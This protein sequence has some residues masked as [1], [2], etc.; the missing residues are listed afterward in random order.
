[1][2]DFAAV[3]TPDFWRR[4]D[5]LLRR[6][7][8]LLLLVFAVF[9]YGQ[10]YRSDL[11]LGGEGGTAAVNALRLNEGWLP[12]KDTTLNYNVMWFYPVAW[13]F[14]LTGPDYVALRIYFFAL[15][16]V[17]GILGF[18]I[19]RRVTGLGWYA[20]GAGLLILAIPGMLFRNYMGL[21]P[22]LNA[23]ALLHAFVLGS[24]AG[25]RRWLWFAG[26]GFVL[27]LT[28]LVRIDVGMFFTV[29]Y[30]G[31]VALY[32]LGVRGEFGRRLPVAV[33]GGVL[34]ALAAV[35]IHL[36]FYLDACRRG[37]GPEFIG[38][39]TTIWNQTRYEVERRLPGKRLARAVP[40][41]PVTVAPAVET[42]WI[43]VHFK[44]TPKNWAEKAK[45]EKLAAMNRSGR[46]RQELR[47]LFRQA[48]FYDA[49]FV[50]ILHLPILISGLVI[51]AAGGALAW[52]LVRAE[53]AR[54]ESALVCLVTLGSA[55][56]L[57]P[58]YFFFRPDTPHLSEF[59]IPFMVAMACAGFY[60]MRLVVRGRSLVV[61]VACGA[62]VTLCLLS[63]T[64]YFFH[65]FRKE[66]AGTIAAARKRS[67]E[68]VCE[69]GVHVF[70]KKGERKRVQ[71]IHDLIM[72]HSAPGEWLVT[73][74]YSPTVNFMTNRPSYLRQ[75][76]VDNASVGRNWV[77]E[78]VA[79]FGKYQP[80][81][82]LID[83]RDINDTEFSRFKN[84]AAPVYEYIRQH[85][86]RVGGDLDLDGNEIYVRPDKVAPQT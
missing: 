48:S 12:I 57:F 81:V 16:L 61:R 40:A 21:L 43:R 14:K 3:L 86:V 65:S 58:Q 79:E 77:E 23:W 42:G 41:A 60:A 20:L 55:L 6:W 10:Y 78:T 82:I 35:A 73:F 19:V 71:A 32:P 85:Y 28:F 38:Q 26:A 75:L 76:Y 2:F 74:P 5:A 67:Y 18:L 11:N 22:L 24:R 8:P 70:L 56:T 4:V 15:C 72:S 54:K 45:A 64:L 1:M 49:V 31:L 80:A 36:P 9:Y 37:F 47:D 27:G 52:A 51:A 29:I 53:A 66:S 46:P 50:L 17:A 30:A 83:Q 68:V 44:R 59:M 69:N 33:G 25:P 13:L 62:F 34:C 39:Y 7:G 84:W 63:E